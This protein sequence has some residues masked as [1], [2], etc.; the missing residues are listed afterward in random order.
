MGAIDLTSDARAAPCPNLRALTIY[1]R[2]DP[3]LVQAVEVAFLGR[4]LGQFHEPAPDDLVN[5]IF[6]F[7]SLSEC[8]SDFYHEY[9][10]WGLLE[11]S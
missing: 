10:I 1:A 8:T 3:A 2:E 9:E 6:Q 5:Q 4:A 7:I 11:S